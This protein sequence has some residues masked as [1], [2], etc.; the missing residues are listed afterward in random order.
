MSAVLV[1]EPFSSK[2]KKKKRDLAAS[3]GKA[4]FFCFANR[5][6]EVESEPQKDAIADLSQAWC[7]T[8]NP[9]L[10]ILP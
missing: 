1:P 4:V 9:D 8:K 10:C 6:T 5:G 2:K 7:G 3:V